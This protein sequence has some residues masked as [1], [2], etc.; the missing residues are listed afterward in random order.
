MNLNTDECISTVL[1]KN[2]S[3]LHFHHL[4]RFW[5]S[6]LFRKSLFQF[7][8]T[9]VSFVLFIF[10]F[11]YC[12]LFLFGF[13][14]LLFLPVSGQFS[15]KEDCPSLVGV[16]VWVSFRVKVRIGGKFSLGAIVLEPFLLVAK[17]HAN[18]ILGFIHLVYV[19]SC[20]FL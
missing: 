15:P 1:I 4:Y 3:I 18:E 20:T 17:T 5:L 9:F 2:G 19:Q 11:F 14:F 8:K 16:R 12:F 10:S 13:W 6:W 7:D